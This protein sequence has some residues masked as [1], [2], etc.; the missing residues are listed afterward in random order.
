MSETATNSAA[1]RRLTAAD[2]TALQRMLARCSARS[3]HQRFGT[4]AP[5]LRTFTESLV[6]RENAIGL[7]SWRGDDLIGV[8]SVHF[9]EDRP[10]FAIL[11]EDAWQRRGVGAHLVR[12]MCDETV[13]AG[14][15]H[16]TVELLVPNTAARALLLSSCSHVWFSMPDAGLV[17]GLVML[18]PLAA[19]REGD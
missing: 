18:R 1:V 6:R 3:L 13:S 9:H 2:G 10:E 15:H 12:A 16:A 14:W 4:A 11:V 5:A 17:S 7:G 8:G 19:P